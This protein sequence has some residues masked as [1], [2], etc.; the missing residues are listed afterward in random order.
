MPQP[1]KQHISKCGLC[2]T[3]DQY[4]DILTKALSLTHFDLTKP[5]LQCVILLLLLKITHHEH[6]G[7][8]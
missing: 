6:A 4:V 7:E 3:L 1:D 2:P 8:I 5:S